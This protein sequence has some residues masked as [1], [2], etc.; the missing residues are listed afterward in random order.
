MIYFTVSSQIDEYQKD[1]IDLLNVNGT[2]QKY[3]FEYEKLMVDLNIKVASPDTP[4]TFWKTLKKDKDEKVDELIAIMSFAYR[5]YFTH[6]EICELY[7]FYKTDSAKKMAS[8][9]DELTSKELEFISNY[10]KSNIAIKVKKVS[11]EFTKDS[12]KISKQWSRELFTEKLGVLAKAGYT[13]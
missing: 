6:P 13:K 2:A 11:A 7:E 9:T 1:I 4:D 10:K 3:D 12:L 5:K 8:G